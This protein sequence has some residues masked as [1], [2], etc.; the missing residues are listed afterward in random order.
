MN[1]PLHLKAT[2]ICCSLNLSVS[3]Q[4]IE[5]IAICNYCSYS[6]V[7]DKARAWGV[8]Y[9]PPGATGIYNSY[10]LGSERIT[11]LKVVKPGSEVE[12]IDGQ[13]RTTA[14]SAVVD[15]IAPARN[16]RTD[17]ADL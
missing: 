14:N 9:L 15:Q 12:V 3:A 4:T 6:E 1:I 2:L 5:D 10:D 8:K 17:S 13:G 16:P 11:T 7:A